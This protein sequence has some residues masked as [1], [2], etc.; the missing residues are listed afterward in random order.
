MNIITLTTDLGIR[1]HYAPVLKAKIQAA[2]EAAEIVDISHNINKFDIVQSAFI[3][4]NTCPQFVESSIHVNCVHL[5]QN[6]KSRLILFKYNGRFYMGPDNGSFSLIFDLKQENIYYFDV[7]LSFA[8]PFFT[9][10]ADICGRIIEGWPL[11]EIGTPCEDFHEI[12]SLRPVLTKNEIRASIMYIDDFGNVIVNIR[13]QEFESIRNG[14][15]F[16]IYFQHD[17]PIRE[18]SKTYADVPIGDVVC[19]FNSSGFLEISVNMGNAHKEL[20]L[21]LDESIQINFL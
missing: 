7:D 8:Y 2:C 20:I 13:Q 14:R 19:L 3:M 6:Q 12:L 1:D 4:K 11:A 21:N 15:P 18:I 9:A 5:Y 16:L 17:N 10:I